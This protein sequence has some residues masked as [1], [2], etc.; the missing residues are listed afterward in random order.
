MTDCILYD[1]SYSDYF[2]CKMWTCLPR[3]LMPMM[4][5]QRAQ[6]HCSGR[7]MIFRLAPSCPEPYS[8]ETGTYMLKGN[9]LFD[10]TEDI[11]ADIFGAWNVDNLFGF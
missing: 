3:E 11:G 4:R 2:R 8:K 1:L 10:V 6:Y 9:E 7:S 5:L